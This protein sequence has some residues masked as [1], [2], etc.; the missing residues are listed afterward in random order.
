MANLGVAV[1]AYTTVFVFGS[2]VTV[3]GGYP[4]RYTVGS[5]VVHVT[6][7]SGTRYSDGV[8]SAGVPKALKISGG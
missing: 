5:E 7:G 1:D 8:P 3:P 2:P 6:G 4:A